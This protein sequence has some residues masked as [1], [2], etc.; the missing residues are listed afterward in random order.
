MSCG[1]W[2]REVNRI[3]EVPHT[4]LAI[5][6]PAV[7]LEVE[8]LLET[9]LKIEAINQSWPRLVGTSHYIR[10]IY[11]DLVKHRAREIGRVLEFLGIENDRELESPLVKLNPTDLRQAIANYDEVARAL[12]GTAFERCLEY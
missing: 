6:T 12:K 9:L 3:L 4:A 7:T 8:K 5:A 1:S 10:V 11:E 2:S